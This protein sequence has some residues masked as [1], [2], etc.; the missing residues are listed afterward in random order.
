M[1]L[2]NA[3]AVHYR[4]WREMHGDE[5][6]YGYGF[7]TPSL[8]EW[9]G[10]VV[11]SEAGLK[12]VIDKYSKMP[13]Y[14]QVSRQKLAHTLRWSPG[15]S[16]Y[17]LSHPNAFESVNGTLAAIS[18]TTHAFN[19]D[20]PRFQEH[21]H[22]L[23]FSLVSVLRRFRVEMLAGSSTPLLSVWFGDQSEEEI[24]FFVRS[25]ND[26]SVA[27]WYFDTVAEPK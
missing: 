14:T 9:A 3:A 7:N 25:C 4:L 2:F 11:F 27:A 21:V 20:D 16:P 17:C 5:S 23:Y 12:E 8:V 6:V 15:D 22:A 24:R 19:G 26:A 18:E 13:Y 10:A 1:Q